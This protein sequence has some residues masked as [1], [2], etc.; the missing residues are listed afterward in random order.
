VQAHS[1]T[2]T[3]SGAPTPSDYAPH[4]SGRDRGPR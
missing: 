1:S 4:A 2:P 3:R